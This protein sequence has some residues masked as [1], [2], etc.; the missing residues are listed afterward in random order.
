MPSKNRDYK[1]E[2]TLFHGQPEEIKRRAGRNAA[3]RKAVASGKAKKGDGKD[4]HHKNG[5]TK[6]N[7]S[8]NTSV[9]SRSKNRA[10]G[11]AKSKPYTKTEKVK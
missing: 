10:M 3:R 1:R 5:D 6:D 4:V 8:K 7:S 11:G 9:I 2:Y